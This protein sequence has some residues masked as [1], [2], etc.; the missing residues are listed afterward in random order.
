MQIRE[1]LVGNLFELKSLIENMKLYDYF[2]PK[3]DE[4]M[5]DIAEDKT[6]VVVMGEFKHGKSTLINAILGEEIMPTDILPSTAVLTTVSRG[7]KEQYHVHYKNGET[8][9]LNNKFD[10]EQ[11]TVQGISVSNEINHIEVLTNHTNFPENIILIDTPGINDLSE[12]RAEV[13]YQF[14]PRAE[15]LIF[16]MSLTNP[17]KKSEVEFIKNYINPLNNQSIIVVGNFMDRLD[18]EEIDEVIDFSKIRLDSAFEKK[19]VSFFPLSAQEAN[20]AKL[21]N[22]LELLESSGYVEFEKMLFDTLNAEVHGQNK[23]NLLSLRYKTIKNSII[24]QIEAEMQIKSAT[25]ENLKSYLENIEKWWKNQHEALGQMELYIHER[26]IEIERMCKK[27]L[28]HFVTSLKMDIVSE[29]NLFNGNDIERFANY[30]LP[31]IIETKFAHWLNNYQDSIAGLLMNL[32]KEIAKGLYKLFDISSLPAVNLNK[33]EINQN[34][35]QIEVK[36]TNSTLIA[37]AILGGVG[38]VALI[39]GAPFFLPL[40]GFAGM[41][42]LVKNLSESKYATLRPKITFETDRRIDTLQDEFYKG[43][44][45]YLEKHI[46]LISQASLNNLEEFLS[47]QKKMLEEELLKHHS[48]KEQLEN[49]KKDLKMMMENILLIT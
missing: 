33:I 28:D 49:E 40:L 13:T 2:S 39:V 12:H 1:I 30:H 3:I 25:E 24:S 17:V 10:L 27:S 32:E 46:I 42:F 36:S 48:N 11:F 26:R 44:K 45:D 19:K 38:T 8:I 9:S 6:T 20:L 7:S 18:E 22:S 47:S 5:A 29:I 37:G 31:Q 35:N 34:I 14:L 16:V 23:I 4:L 21:E 41:P 15:I 43:I